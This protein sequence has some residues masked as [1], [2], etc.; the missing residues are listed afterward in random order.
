VPITE[1]QAQARIVLIVG[2]V[3]PA[4]GAPPDFP[5][6]GL[7]A[8]NIAA[9]WDYH[10]AADGVFVGLRAMYVERDAIEA[11]LGVLRAQVDLKAGSA[12]LALSQKAKV[13]MERLVMLDSRILIVTRAS[14]A[15]VAAVGQIAQTAPVMPADAAVI[16][17][18]LDANS[19]GFAGSPYRRSWLGG[20]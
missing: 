15:G 7:L 18:T 11:V 14:G 5:E 10:A 8:L 3:D 17:T 1:A 19:P 9:L 2:D 12:S 4:T 16:P 6:D 20:R 13:L